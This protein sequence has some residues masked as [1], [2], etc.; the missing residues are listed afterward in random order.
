M[1]AS[2][3]DFQVSHFPKD[4]LSIVLSDQVRKQKKTQSPTK[5]ITTKTFSNKGD[6]HSD[7]WL[8]LPKCRGRRWVDSTN[9]DAALDSHH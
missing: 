9:K 1:K 3:I 6:S 8:K 5:M 2:G 7:S 4:K